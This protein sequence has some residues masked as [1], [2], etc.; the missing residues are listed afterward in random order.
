MMHGGL[1]LGLRVPALAGTEYAVLHRVLYGP[2][3]GK[4]PKGLNEWDLQ[5]PFM[6]IDSHGPVDI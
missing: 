5:I 3:P 4:V 2:C 1:V 6:G